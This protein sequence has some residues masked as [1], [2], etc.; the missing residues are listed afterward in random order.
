MKSYCIWWNSASEIK[1]SSLW[2]HNICHD[3]VLL[4][5][6]RLRAELQ[7]LLSEKKQISGDEK[8]NT[9]KFLALELP[10]SHN[11]GWSKQIRR[12]EKFFTALY[13]SP[14][15]YNCTYMSARPLVPHTTYLI[16]ITSYMLKILILY[17]IYCWIMAVLMIC[18]IFHWLASCCWMTYHN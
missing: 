4:F 8:K 2:I 17:H 5:L 3:S 10:P 9:E 16:C 1:I 12:F 18:E 6:L 13:K 11:A 14:D 15:M 7:S